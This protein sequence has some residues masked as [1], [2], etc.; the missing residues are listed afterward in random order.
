[1]SKHTPGPW[2]Q[3]DGCILAG[4]DHLVCFGHDYDEYGSISAPWKGNGEAQ[5]E[6]WEQEAAANARLIAAAPDLLA[7]LVEAMGVMR[8]SAEE[9]G[10]VPLWNIG[11]NGYLA[12]EQARTA[13][14]KATQEGKR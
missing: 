11:G 1:M 8:E 4:E 13:I 14:K 3:K 2:T 7:A 6:A 5:E 12:C 10:D 9:A